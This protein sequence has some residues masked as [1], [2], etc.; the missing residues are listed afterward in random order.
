MLL[1][2]GNSDKEEV[3]DIP[4][5]AECRIPNAECRSDALIRLYPYT[6]IPYTPYTT[7]PP[8]EI[9][10]RGGSWKIEDWKIEKF[11]DSFVSRGLLRHLFPILV[12]YSPIT[13]ITPISLISLY[14]YTPAP[15]STQYFTAE[16]TERITQRGA[17]APSFDIR[18]SLFGIRHSF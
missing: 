7:I 16:D 15:N 5:N 17:E 12:P 11:E 3:V 10:L 1:V 2:N 8:G 13:H 14:P 4:R 6:S 18:H 9:V